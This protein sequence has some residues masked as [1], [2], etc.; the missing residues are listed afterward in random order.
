IT[1]VHA[2]LDRMEAERIRQADAARLAVL[3]APYD[4]VLK[5]PSMSAEIVA[6]ALQR[7]AEHAAG[8]PAEPVA[9]VAVVFAAD[10]T[11]LPCV[12]G[13]WARPVHR[14]SDGEI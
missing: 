7:A 10:G 13:P 5:E 4:H 6:E 11:C 2:T 3:T 8:L 14:D 9:V 1:E 12:L